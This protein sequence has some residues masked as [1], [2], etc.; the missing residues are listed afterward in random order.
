MGGYTLINQLSRD[1][2]E[3]EVKYEKL[4]AEKDEEIRKLKENVRG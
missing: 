1:L 3:T 4:I 2:E